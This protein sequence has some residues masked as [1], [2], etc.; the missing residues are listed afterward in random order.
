VYAFAIWDARSRKLVQIQ[1]QLGIKPLYV[2]GTADGVSSAQPK[3]ILA[4]P[5]ARREVDADGL[6]ELFAS[7]RTPHNAIWAG[8]REVEPGTIV[9]VD[10]DGSASAAT[11]GWPLGLTM[12]SRGRRRAG[13]RAGR[14][15]RA[16]PAG[17]G[18]A[19]LRAALGRA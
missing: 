5:L 8:M 3:A 19:A 14:R 16:P 13:A 9:T 7:V 1:D 10:A 6:R 12:A 17:R 18:R 15:H 11:G 4:N 2:Y